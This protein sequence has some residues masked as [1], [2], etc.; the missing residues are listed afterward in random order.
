MSEPLTWVVGSG[1]L[2]GSSVTAACRERGPLWEPPARIRWQQADARQ[3]LAG[4]VAEFAEAV[5]SCAWQVAWCAG[6]AT[7]TASTADLAEERATFDFVLQ[8]LARRIAPRQWP[9]GGLFVASSAGGVYAGSSDPP[10]TE[11]SVPRPI[12]PYGE[13]KLE[14]ERSASLW[15]QAHGIPVLIGRIAN[16][17]GPGQ[18][19]SKAQGLVSQLCRAHLRREPI[20]IYVPLDTVRDYLYVADCGE[21]VADALERLCSPAASAE[22]SAWVKVFASQQGVTIA[23]LLG[24]LKRL[25]KRPLHVILP[26]SD[27]ARFQARDLRLRSTTWTDLDHRRM[28]PLTAGIRATVDHLSRALRSGPL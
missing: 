4:A 11:R 14:L 9:S 17:Y 2:L 23:A 19:M 1:G 16:L 15:G 3:Q 5:G 8:H 27:A 28:T 20:R 22:D 7:T 10:F 24:H 26:A 12:S 6:A 25:F 21:M 13:A 18:D